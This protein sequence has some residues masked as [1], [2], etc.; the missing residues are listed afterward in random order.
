MKKLLIKLRNWSAE[1]EFTLRTGLALLT[2][3]NFA[4][5][6]FVNSKRLSEVIGL[7]E[8]V[9]IITGVPLGMLGVWIVGKILIVVGW[10]SRNIKANVERNPIIMEILEKV[11][12]IEEHQKDSWRMGKNIIRKLK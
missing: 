7:S 9:I 10:K 5:L 12:K 6:I 11:R 2:F 8:K 3:V 4:L 1:Q